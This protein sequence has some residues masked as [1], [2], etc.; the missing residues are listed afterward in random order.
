[1][2]SFIYL[3][4]SAKRQQPVKLPDKVKQYL[5]TL[6]NGSQ[7]KEYYVREIKK[8][9]SE[10]GCSMGARF[11]FGSLVIF[12]FYI[13]FSKGHPFSQMLKTGLEG[14][15]IVFIISLLGKLTGVGVARRRLQ[16]LYKEITKNISA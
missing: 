16:R 2:V 9:N 8:Y 10:C 6:P 1:M 15:L 11:L 14:L 7:E 12:I 4:P 13:L 3:Y 5:N